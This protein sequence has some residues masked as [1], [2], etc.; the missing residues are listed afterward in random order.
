MSSDSSHEEYVTLHPVPAMDGMIYDKIYT[1][2]HIETCLLFPVQYWQKLTLI[3]S[4]FWWEE[5]TVQ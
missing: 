5:K 4:E 1:N 3:A 2:I